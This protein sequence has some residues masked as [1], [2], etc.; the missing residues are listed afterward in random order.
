MI[1]NRN[2]GQSK[3]LKNVILKIITTSD[4]EL[5]G[6]TNKSALHIFAKIKL[7]NFLISPC[8]PPWMLSNAKRLKYAT[9]L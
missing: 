5:M 7:L 3:V 9:A 8:V 2:R 4:R 6:Q 1:L